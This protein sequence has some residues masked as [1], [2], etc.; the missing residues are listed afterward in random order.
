MPSRATTTITAGSD[1]RM[2]ARRRRRSS[3]LRRGR[4]GWP[5]D[6]PRASSGVAS[7]MLTSA[8]RV[9]APPLRAGSWPNVVCMLDSADFGEM[10][11]FSTDGSSL[12]PVFTTLPC[13]TLSSIG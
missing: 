8:S 6:L 7:E 13:T 9:A 1:S 2:P 4:A 11:P 10:L 3:R 5:G 12:L